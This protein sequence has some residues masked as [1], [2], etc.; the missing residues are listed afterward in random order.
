MA[1]YNIDAMLK[2]EV[3][4]V[5]ICRNIKSRDLLMKSLKAPSKNGL[6]KEIIKLNLT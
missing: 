2:T 1:L 4:L 6:H 3:N 5:G